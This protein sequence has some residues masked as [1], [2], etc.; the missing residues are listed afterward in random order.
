[1]LTLSN[2]KDTLLTP[3]DCGRNDFSTVIQR[4]IRCYYCGT[5]EDSVLAL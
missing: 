1:M 3:C 5:E 4:E 2:I